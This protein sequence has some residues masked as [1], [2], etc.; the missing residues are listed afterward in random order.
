MP[1]CPTTTSPTPASALLGNPSPRW[2]GFHEVFHALTIAA[3]VVH[4]IGVSLLAQASLDPARTRSTLEN[5][6]RN[7]KHL[8]ELTHKLEAVARMNTIALTASITSPSWLK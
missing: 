5:L 8:V 1:T 4:Y 3:F 7:V 6:E 2:F